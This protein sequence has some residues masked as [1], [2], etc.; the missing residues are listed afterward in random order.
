MGTV[1]GERKTQ[2]RWGRQY[3]SAPE[4][5]LACAE[6]LGV[7]VRRVGHVGAE[8]SA[9]RGGVADDEDVARPRATVGEFLTVIVKGGQGGAIAIET[10]SEAPVFDKL[11]ACWDE[12]AN[13][14]GQYAC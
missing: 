3:T 1:T 4:E 7:R 12:K 8:Y 5:A 6:E 10:V 13:F 9:C 2:A 14:F 11:K